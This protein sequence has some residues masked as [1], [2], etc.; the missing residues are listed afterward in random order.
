MGMEISYSFSFPWGIVRIKLAASC[1]GSALAADGSRFCGA[2]WKKYHIIT[3][4]Q[5]Q[6]VGGR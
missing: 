5:S 2:V 1:M 6:E 4:H 3:S